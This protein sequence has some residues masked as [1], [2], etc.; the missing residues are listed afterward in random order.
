MST[1]SGT[2]SARFWVRVRRGLTS[3][4][5]PPLSGTHEVEWSITQIGEHGE[6]CLDPDVIPDAQDEPVRRRTPSERK[7]EV[8]RRER[9]FWAEYPHLER[10]SLPRRKALRNRSHRH[11]VR[12]SIDQVLQTTTLLEREDFSPSLHAA[13]SP[14]N[15]AARSLCAAGSKGSSQSLATD[16]PKSLQ[17]PSERC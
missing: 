1:T 15:A 11:R 9:R 13:S 3:P 10:R 14:S 8:Y 12:E 17:R 4:L 16:R 6:T 5:G 7:A 2:T